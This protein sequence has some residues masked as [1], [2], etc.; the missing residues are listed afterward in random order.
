[1]P[2]GFRVF[3][4]LLGGL[5]LGMGA[6]AIVGDVVREAFDMN[7]MGGIASGLGLGLLATAFLRRD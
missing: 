5:L 6:M 7:P 2:Y 1:M 4:A 3:C